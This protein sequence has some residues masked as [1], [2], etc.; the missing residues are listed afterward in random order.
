MSPGLLIVGVSSLTSW[1][2]VVQTEMLPYAT[3]TNPYYFPVVTGAVSQIINRV[4][5][6]HAASDTP[7]QSTSISH[8]VIPAANTR[9]TLTCYVLRLEVHSTHIIAHSLFWLA[10][11][12]D[13][14]VR[15]LHM[16]YP[17][18]LH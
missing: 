14:A 13:P 7:I 11:P 10:D 8:Y 3:A 9:I 18:K 4:Q 15:L 6:V 2:E 16:L 17:S 1:Q 12:G 5:Q